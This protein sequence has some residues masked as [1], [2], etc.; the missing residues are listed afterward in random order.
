MET[1]GRFTKDEARLDSIET[2]YSNLNA[3]MKNLETQMG[4]LA[5]ELKNKKKG[6][7]P[8]DMKQNPR[9]NCKAITLRSGKEVESS[10]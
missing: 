9:D 4:Q 3:T 8:S 1:R 10:R 7:F 5:S 6:K 2:R